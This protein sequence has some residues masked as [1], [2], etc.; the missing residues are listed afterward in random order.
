MSYRLICIQLMLFSLTYASFLHITTPSSEILPWLHGVFSGAAIAAYLLA[1]RLRT[2][3]H[4]L[5][6]LLTWSLFATLWSLGTVGVTQYWS[7]QLATNQ[8]VE[9]VLFY[10]TS[11]TQFL[12]LQDAILFWLLLIPAALISLLI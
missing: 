6:R 4:R 11:G 1:Q 3:S 2:Q 10:G 8:G 9:A 12:S 7:A 5:I